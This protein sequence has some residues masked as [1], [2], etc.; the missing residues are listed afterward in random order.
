MNTVLEQRF[1]KSEPQAADENQFGDRRRKKKQRKEIE[2]QV[3]PGR[4]SCHRGLFARLLLHLFG[5]I[6]AT[7]RQNVF[8][9][10]LDFSQKQADL[11]P[12][13]FRGIT[14]TT[15]VSPKGGRP[16]ARGSPLRDTS[17][18]WTHSTVPCAL[19]AENL[20]QVCTHLAM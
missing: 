16:L 14:D 3:P 2:S 19:T 11:L 13:R 15:H 17:H 20:L 7:L 12:R 1:F 6:N 18:V 4:L 5:S 8:P 9:R 10:R